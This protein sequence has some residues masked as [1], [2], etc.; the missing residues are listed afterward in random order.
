MFL[1]CATAECLARKRRRGR[2]PLPPPRP[3]ALHF[4]REPAVSRRATLRSSTHV[5]DLTSAARLLAQVWHKLVDNLNYY[6][7]EYS[8]LRVRW[9]RGCSAFR[10]CS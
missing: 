10:R 1:Q 9:E 5:R 7:T 4:T 3:A 6:G 8:G 2:I